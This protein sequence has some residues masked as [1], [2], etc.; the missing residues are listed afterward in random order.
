MEHKQRWAVRAVIAGAGVLALAGIAAPAAADV[1]VTPTEAVQGDGADLTLR[2]TNESRTASVTAIDLRLPADTPIAEVYPLSVDDWAPAM[3]NEKV[4][5]PLASLHGYQI[6]EVTTAITWIAMPDRA[7]PPGKTTELYL[8]IGPLPAVDRLAFAVVLTNSDGTRT[9]LTVP[10]LALKPGEGTA[11]A[12]G[13]GE[14]EPQPQPVAQ[15]ETGGPSYLLW[16]LV[17]LLGIGV[18]CI[19]SVVLQNRRKP[20]PAPEEE[21]KEMVSAS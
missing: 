15:A 10:A 3:T 16:S 20:V 4:D 12:A 11:H 2:I 21:S 1:V 7:L 13:H 5:K 6:T 19:V 8:S 9:N 18:V 17:A 14:A